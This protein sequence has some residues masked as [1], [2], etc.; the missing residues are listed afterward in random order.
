M[1]GYEDVNVRIEARVPRD[2]GRHPADHAV[3]AELKDEVRK[4][5]ADPRFSSIM[6]EIYYGD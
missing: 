3:W 1:S 5:C 6:P 2:D 4:L